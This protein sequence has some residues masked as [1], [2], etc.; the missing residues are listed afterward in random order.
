VNFRLNIWLTRGGSQTESGGPQ[1]AASLM[2][3]T[4]RQL[5]PPTFWLVE[6]DA[7]GAWPFWPA[8]FP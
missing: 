3:P 5:L 8:A 7:G 4:S 6:G 1:A 2:Q